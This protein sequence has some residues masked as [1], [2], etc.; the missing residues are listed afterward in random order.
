MNKNK[1]GIEYDKMYNNKKAKMQ[2]LHTHV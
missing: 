1:K 2:G